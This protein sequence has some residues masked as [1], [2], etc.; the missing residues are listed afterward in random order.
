MM[1][2]NKLYTKPETFTPVRF[3]SGINLII[4]EPNPT[5]DKTNGVG[6]TLLI[7]F[8][9][10]CLFK[11]YN[12]SR[13]SKIP[14][15]SYSSETTICLDIEI[16]GTNYTIERNIKNH[17]EPKIRFLNIEKNFDSIQDAIE[18]LTTKLFTHDITGEVPSFRSMMGPLIRDEGSEFKSIV[19]CFDT[20]IKA[21]ANLSPHLYLFGLKISPYKEIKRLINEIDKSVKIKS[22]LKNDIELLSGVTISKAKAE[23]NEINSQVEIINSE[24]ESLDNHLSYDFIREEVSNLEL[25]IQSLRNKKYILKS[26]LNKI[27][28]LSG[29]NFINDSEV[30]DL[31]NKFKNGL[32]DILSKEL[33]E[34]I[35]FKKSIDNFQSKILNERK[36]VISEEINDIDVKLKSAT[37][38]YA[39]KMKAFDAT[40]S[41]INLKQLILTHQRKIEEQSMLST[42]LKKYKEEDD[43]IKHKKSEK[44]ALVVEID[45]DINRN[46]TTI[47][48]FQETILL[49]HDY[50]FGNKKCSFEI[51]A[52]DKKSIVDFTLRID[53]DGS[54]SN[55]REKVFFYDISLLLT[56]KT[57]RNHPGLLIH[58]NIF[59]V[60]NDTLIKSLNFL[61]EKSSCLKDCQYILTLN[62]D[63]LSK[64]DKKKLKLDINEYKRISLTKKN[65]FLGRV[66]QQK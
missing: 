66:Y 7:E 36:I 38:L 44:S 20:N 12:F 62:S 60:D 24:M 10:F 16:D 34:V 11:E 52:N 1:K 31:Y 45:L 42:M 50:V 4:G 8:I 5:S 48:D 14:S 23:L 32:G 27:A 19:N 17:N 37:S 30:V 18:F 26:E 35:S 49:M 6:K 25:S 28:L 22:K 56:E 33:S 54:H 57:F 43:I 58:D 2:I 15:S 63:K 65:R 55:E 29:D 13:I 46:K 47:S 53:D 3:F 61:A 40:G 51:S 41:L 9:N 39:E 21:A 59:D 64:L